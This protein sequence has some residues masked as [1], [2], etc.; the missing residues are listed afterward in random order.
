M[1]SAE[2]LTFESR[3]QNNAVFIIDALG[4][5]DLQT[6]RRLNDDLSSLQLSD[7]SRYCHYVKVAALSEAE[8]VLQEILNS[9]QR[10]LKP[11]IHI[12]AH[13][14]QVEGLQIAD[15]QQFLSWEI[16][17][18]W[19]LR[20]NT[21]TGNNLGVVLASC[22][23]LYAITPITIHNPCPFYFLI[24]SNRTV[25]A[26][27]ID[28]TMCRFYQRLF[29]ERN[30]DEAMREVD[31]EFKQFQA[32]KFFCIT[33]GKYMRRACMGKGANERVEKL[34][35]AALACGSPR[36]AENLKRLRASAKQFV[37]SLDRQRETY[38]KIGRFFLHGKLPIE[39]EEFA[40]FV[41][42]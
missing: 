31:E 30:L 39:F 28:D 22:F 32:E 18:Q 35:S 40:R 12:E 24:G 2:D 38:E 36:T 26:G 9:C 1:A 3:F 4:D 42:R 6:A 14:S 19:C 11:V 17:A 41:R 20:I 25:S 29:D 10:G 34:I 37:R 13:G 5:S 8:G 15:S 16:L 21:I 23:G 7:G 27:Y 33:F